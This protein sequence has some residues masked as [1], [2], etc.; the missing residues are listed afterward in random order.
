MEEK[1]RR[2]RNNN[3]ANIDAPIHKLN[4]I[5]FRSHA[6]IDTIYIYICTYIDT[7][8]HTYIYVHVYTDGHVPFKRGLWR[9]RGKG[10]TIA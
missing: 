5:R 1:E 4:R 3:P 6:L 2:Q 10:Y 9:V 7:H 8:I